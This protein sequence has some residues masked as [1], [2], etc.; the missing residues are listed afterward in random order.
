M[1]RRPL[2]PLPLAGVASLSPPLARGRSPAMCHETS[3][4]GARPTRPSVCCF[5]PIGLPSCSR[6]VPFAPPPACPRPALFRAYCT[7]S[8]ARVPRRRGLRARLRARASARRTSPVH[9]NGEFSRQRETKRPP[10]VASFCLILAWIAENPVLIQDL[11]LYCAKLSSSIAI[12][13]SS[14]MLSPSPAPAAPGKARRPNA[15]EVS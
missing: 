6:F 1:R 15:G 2:P 9:S 7:R 12:R 14:A 4:S 3:C 13:A 11:F 10:D 5:L 8:R